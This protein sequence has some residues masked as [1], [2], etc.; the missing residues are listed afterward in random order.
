ME[1]FELRVRLICFFSLKDQL[2]LMV[3]LQVNPHGARWQLVAEMVNIYCNFLIN[4]VFWRTKIL[5][6]PLR[7][8]H[9]SK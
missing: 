9:Q 4:F 3:P 7:V 1:F 5:R 2:V 6:A 8:K